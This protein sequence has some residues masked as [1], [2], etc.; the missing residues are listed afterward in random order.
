MRMVRRNTRRTKI[1]KIMRLKRGHEI[2]AM[3][4]EEIHTD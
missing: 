1:R 4:G 2:R 3:L